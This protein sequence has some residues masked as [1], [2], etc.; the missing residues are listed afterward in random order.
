MVLGVISKIAHVDLE[1]FKTQRVHANPGVQIVKGF[2]R[3]F[4]WLSI[5]LHHAVVRIVGL[6]V[7]AA[8]PHALGVH[9]TYP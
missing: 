2:Q 6:D 8:K 3:E 7:V 5:G 9:A 4:F 1:L